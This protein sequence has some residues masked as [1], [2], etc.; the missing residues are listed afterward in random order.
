MTSPEKPEG[1]SIEAKPATYHGVVFRST[2]EANWAAT[3][4]QFGIVWEYEPE[5][6][7]LPS[8]TTYIPD[9]R[10]PELGTWLE[11]KGPTVPRIEKAVELGRDRKSTRLN[12]SHYALS[13]MP[14]SA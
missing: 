8:G 13:R 6:F 9:F 12:S 2:L 14:S 7:T 10:L 3:L 11:V 4:D 1:P 5:V